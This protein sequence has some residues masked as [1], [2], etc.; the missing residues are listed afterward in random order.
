MEY[1][2][3]LVV[4]LVVFGGST[5]I[6]FDRERAF[7][8]VVMIVIAAYYILFAAMAASTSVLMLE[9]LA[10][11]VFMTAAAIGFRASLWLVVAAL[12]GHGVFDIFHHYIIENPGVP[13]WWPGFC[14]AADVAAAAYL[15][16]LLKKRPGLEG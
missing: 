6:G 7:Y 12:A 4:A 1:L 14:M 15:A 2:I 8:P 10:A 16:V 5:V 9:C 3:G 11:A 13:S